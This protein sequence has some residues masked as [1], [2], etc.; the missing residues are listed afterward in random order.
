[1]ATERKF[2]APFDRVVTAERVRDYKPALAHFRRFARDSGATRAD[3]VHVA[4]SWF[5]D[6]APAREL[7]LPRVW[8]DRDRT[9]DDPAAASRRIPDATALADTVS[10]LMGR[11]E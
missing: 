4:C 8:V 2:R 6:I 7:G 3:W 11:G 9:G 1:V 5:H 10:E